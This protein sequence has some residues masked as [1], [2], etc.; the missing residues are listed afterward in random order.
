MI[1]IIL[2]KKSSYFDQFLDALNLIS[3][4]SDLD[5]G[6][7]NTKYGISRF[8]AS[9]RGS[10]FTPELPPAPY[11]LDLHVVISNVAT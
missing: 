1:T 7:T 8:S 2:P 4:E 6:Y 11:M 3:Y 10:F 5:S 9:G